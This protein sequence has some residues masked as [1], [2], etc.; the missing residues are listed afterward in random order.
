[1]NRRAAADGG[2]VAVEFVL[3]APVLMLVLLFVVGAGRIAGADA[4][5]QGA[6]SDAAR[7]AS[8]TDSPA[9]AVAA[10]RTAATADLTGQQMNCTQ[11]AVSVDTTLFRPGGLVRVS[12]AC[13]ADLSGLTGTGLPGHKTLTATMAAPIEIYRGL[14]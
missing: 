2:S 5:V 4:L 12:V 13:T 10:A 3:L 14:P 6:A 7:A 1:M 11:L 8:L 9:A